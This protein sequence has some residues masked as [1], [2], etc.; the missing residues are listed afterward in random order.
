MEETTYKYI[1]L[2]CAHKIESLIMCYLYISGI[3]LCTVLV[4]ACTVTL[5]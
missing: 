5:F 2:H 4:I 3:L 1:I